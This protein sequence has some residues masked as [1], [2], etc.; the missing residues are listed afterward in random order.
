MKHALFDPSRHD[1][2]DPNPWMAVYMDR[3]LPIADEVKRAW[4]TDCASRS[5]QWLLP[6]VRPFARLAVVFVQLLKMVTPAHW[7]SSTLLHRIIAS[8]LA[9]FATPEANW[10]I[11]RHFHIGAMNLAW[12]NANLANGAVALDTIRPAR[13]DDLRDHLF[14]RHDI[15]LYNFII[16]LN[17]HLDGRPIE[18][19]ALEDMDFSMLPDDDFVGVHH[20]DQPR[21]RFNV[22]DLHTAIELFT[23]LYGLLLTDTDF[24]RATHSLQLDET[25]A[26]YGA[27]L[28]GRTDAL[29][30]V[31]N[32]HPMVPDITMNG[33]F[34]LILHGL[35]TEIMF[36]VLMDLKQAQQRLRSASATPR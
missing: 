19:M 16:G 25:I 33:G 22:V 20:V 5:R 4:L 26:S 1:P 6:V 32:R 13:L 30:Y 10:L 2:S 36:A 29:L 21:G 8:A 3:S 31:N 7:Q 15:N 12:L 14:V 35:A 23:P 24:W 9:R 28:T 18:K 34:R 27:A 11:L 17:L